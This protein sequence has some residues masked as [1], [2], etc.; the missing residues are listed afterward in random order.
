[1]LKVIM[2]NG[3]NLDYNEIFIFCHA[4]GAQ[5]EFIFPYSNFGERLK[6]LG[7]ENPGEF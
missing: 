7:K 6:C 1:M 2:D 4:Q 5:N 3:H